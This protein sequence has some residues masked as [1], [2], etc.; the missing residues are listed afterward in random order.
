MYTLR[1]T[2]AKWQVGSDEA[3]VDIGL[4]K[5]TF[6][7]KLFYFLEDK[8][9]AAVVAKSVENLLMAGRMC[10]IDNLGHGSNS[11]FKISNISHGPGTLRFF[12][13]SIIST[14]PTICMCETSHKPI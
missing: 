3:I 8:K 12:G 14:A 4:T 5:L 1:N 6:F 9:L 7:P 10:I 11:K 13:L 2:N